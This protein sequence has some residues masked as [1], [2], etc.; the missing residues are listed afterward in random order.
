MLQDLTPPQVEEALAWLANPLSLELPQP[1]KQ[2]SEVEMFLLSRMLETLLEEKD[3]S[4]L[5]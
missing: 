4:P 2:L 5:H 1:M 3:S